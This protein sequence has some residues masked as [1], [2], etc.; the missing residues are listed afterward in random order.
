[1]AV[2]NLVK[3]EYMLDNL[4][5]MEIIKNNRERVTLI[6]LGFYL[7]RCPTSLN[8]LFNL[9]GD[10]DRSILLEIKIMNQQNHLDN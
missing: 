9:E 10:W 7:S 2:G 4:L 6:V 8:C 1:M 3:I 5:L